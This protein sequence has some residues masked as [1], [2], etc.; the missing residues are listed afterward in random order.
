[1]YLGSQWNAKNKSELVSNNIGFVLNV[2]KEADTN[3][4]P[5]YIEYKSVEY[6]III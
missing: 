5:D 4:L 1:M 3:V 6:N 2:A